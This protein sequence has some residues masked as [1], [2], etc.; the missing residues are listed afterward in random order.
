MNVERVISLGLAIICVG[1]GWWSSVLNTELHNALSSAETWKESAEKN[2]AALDEITSVHDQL[3]RALK[4]R[5]DTL[6][7]LKQER[8]RQRKELREAMTNDKTA[9]DFGSITIPPAVDRLLR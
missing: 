5:E 6:L 8:E 1:L 4:E 9:S 2:R 3:Q 7:T